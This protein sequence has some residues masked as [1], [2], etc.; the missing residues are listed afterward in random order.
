MPLHDT[1]QEI[2]YGYCQCGC[3]LPAPISQL[4]DSKRGYVKGEPRRFIIG[5]HNYVRPRKTIEERFWERVDKRGPDECWPWT[6]YDNG[7]GYGVLTTQ[8]LNSRRKVGA[9]RFSYELHN[10]P[11]PDG[12]DI[13]HKCDN[14]PC[15]NPAHLF[16]GT[17]MDNMTDMYS[18]GRRKPAKGERISRALF[19]N[20]QV[21]EFRQA[22]AAGS[23]T[24]TEFAR[25]RDV[26]PGTMRNI[27]KRISYQD[28]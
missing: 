5:H 19:S 28:A 4:N 14:P 26:H 18:K 13:L 27:L 21:R 17:H 10:G 6:G 12:L 8:V 15:C 11:I 22:F 16:A 7:Y 20:A 23:Y 25:L 2:P 1:T 9:H 24:V 3:G